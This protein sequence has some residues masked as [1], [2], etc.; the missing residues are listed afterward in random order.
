[1]I[2]L[3]NTSNIKTVG[4]LRA[5]LESIPDSALLN[6]GTETNGYMVNRIAYDGLS[7]AIMTGE[8]GNFGEEE[9]HD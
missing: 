1:M 8:V 5:A 4:Q 9:E 2:K 3:L 7:V 6:I